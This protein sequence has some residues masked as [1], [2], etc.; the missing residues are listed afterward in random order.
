MC[1]RPCWISTAWSDTGPE[2]IPPAAYFSLL[3]GIVSQLR[4]LKYSSATAII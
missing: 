3:Q 2:D 4:R 1:V